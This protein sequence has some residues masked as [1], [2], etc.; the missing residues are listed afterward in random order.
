MTVTVSSVSNLADLLQL[1]ESNEPEQW[2]EIK[3]LIYEQYVSTKESWLVHGLFEFYAHSGSPRCLEL[4]L[5]VREPHERF[6][7]DKMAEGIKLNQEKSR[8]IALAMLGFIVRKQPSWL[9]KITQHSLMKEVLKV[10]KH[11]EDLGVLMT[12][13]MDIL[14][15]IPIVPVYISPYLQ[16]LFEIF[17]RVAS[18]RYQS[19]KGLP[20]VQQ[21]HV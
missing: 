20:E 8:Q 13:L 18:W 3:N 11:E 14:V 17:S 10:L 19:I 2:Q 21:V 6:L 5:N 4:L 15:L 1:I 7:C 9:Y 16:D 12:A